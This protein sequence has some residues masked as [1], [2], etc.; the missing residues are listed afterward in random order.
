MNP[1]P[2][3]NPYIVFQPA[4]NTSFSSPFIFE[5]LTAPMAPHIETPE[6]EK[7]ALKDPHHD[8]IFFTDP[9]FK[10]NVNAFWGTP[11]GSNTILNYGNGTT[12]PLTANYRGLAALIPRYKPADDDLKIF[13]ET[14]EGAAAARVKKVK[15]ETERGAK[16]RE[17]QHTRYRLALSDDN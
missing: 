11:K 4:P 13:R 17:L 1:Q 9:A 15:P 5:A 6:S 12:N 16:I 2:P 7:S 3:A 8:P 14:S 10:H